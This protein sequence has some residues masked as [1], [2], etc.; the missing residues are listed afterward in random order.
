MYIYMY[1][2]L[3]YRNVTSVLQFIFNAHEAD[4]LR[5]FTT[6]YAQSAPLLRPGISSMS[7]LKA[8]TVVTLQE[9]HCF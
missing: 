4:F 3:H 7:S 6:N 5:A 1:C 2:F 8:C 9:H